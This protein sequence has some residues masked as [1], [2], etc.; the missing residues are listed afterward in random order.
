MSGT[1]LPGPVPTRT[2]GVLPGPV[3]T[4]TV[5]GALVDEPHHDGSPM[6]V[7]PS[8]RELGGRVRVRL[9]VP[10]ACGTERVRLRS[11]PDAEPAIVEALIDRH[12]HGATWW[13][14]DLRLH[15]PVTSYRWL[16]DG[17]DLGRCWVNGAGVFHRD[18]SDDAD[19]RLSTWFPEARAPGTTAGTTR[20][21]D[22]LAGTVGYQIF[23]DRFANSDVDR[24]APDWAIPRGWDEPIEDTPGMRA[25]HW[26]GGDL[27]GIET[28]LDHLVHLGVSL[29][30]LTPFFPA[31][32]MHRYDASTFD[33]VDPAL[34]G[35]D[36]L[37]SLVSAAHER[38]IRVIGDI[39]LNH[40][41]AHH[42][43]FEAA[44]AD[45]DAAEHGFYFSTTPSRSATWR[46]TGC[47]RCRNSTIEAQNSASVCTTAM[48]RWPPD[49]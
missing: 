9:R 17:G 16:L 48:D 3:P 31:G 1:V 38:G 43:W 37:V 5:T 10:D 46:G 23:I 14:A 7:D 21:P 13:S 18:V 40:T 8:P 11:T 6:Y 42:D 22:W 36:A 47:G 32:S 33:H 45:P 35:D 34:G 15:N 30:Y 2:V 27:A 24:P 39:T 25:R 41:G 20:P 26:Y 29:I 19:F 44:A 28:H 49:T 4:R 12:E